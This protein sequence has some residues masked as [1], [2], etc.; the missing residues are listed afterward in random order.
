MVEPLRSAPARAHPAPSTWRVAAALGIVYVVWGSTYAAIRVALE[1]FPPF[2]L[3]ATRFL[4]AGTLMLGAALALGARL[5]PR[6]QVR[7]AAIV[8]VLLL[9]VGNGGVVWAEQHV[10]SGLAA[11]IVATVPLWMVGLDALFPRGE[12]LSSA[13]VG[14]SLVGLAGVVLL[15]AGG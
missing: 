9:F 11:V 5:P 13:I 4:A 1:G 3:G 8:G 6:S 10:A 2:L 7:T 14:S 15:M 12:K